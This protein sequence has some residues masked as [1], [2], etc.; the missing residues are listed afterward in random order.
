MYVY[1]AF[2]LSV[3]TLMDV[4]VGSTFL[5]LQNCWDWMLMSRYVWAPVFDSFGYIPRHGI[6]GLYGNS[7]FNF[8]RNYHQIVFHKKFTILHSHQQCTRVL[9]FPH[10][11][12]HVFPF[13]F[14]RKIIIIVMGL[15]W[16]LIVTLIC[17]PLMT[18][19]KRK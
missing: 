18:N 8:Q 14:L 4:W 3:Y 19:V 9:V 11:H 5:L 6:A 7:I 12:W 16:Y 10:H 1:I 2:C 13:F 17:I 15:E